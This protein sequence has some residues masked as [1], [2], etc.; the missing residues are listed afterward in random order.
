MKLFVT[1]GKGFVGQR[2]SE[3][4]G[5]HAAGFELVSPGADFDVTQAGAVSAALEEAAPDAVLHLA[6]RSHA[7]DAWADPLRSI[8][9]N[10]GGTAVLCRALAEQQFAGP[11][12][13]VS[14]S[15]VY[16][17]VGPEALPISEE[18]RPAPSNPYAA[19][20]SAA[21][22][23]ALQWW[24][25]HGLR[26]IVARPFP[27][28][29]PGQPARFVL[30][31]FARQVIQAKH[32]KISEVVAGDL[33]LIRDFSWVDDVVAAYLALLASGE[34]GQI[35]NVCSGCEQ[36]LR[37][38]LKRMMAL[39]DVDLPIRINPTRLRVGDQRRVVGSTAKLAACCPQQVPHP[40]SDAH[41]SAILRY[42]EGIE[43]PPPVP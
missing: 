21:E 2:V 38:L 40:L 3:R 24:R 12:L 37:S 16:G 13:I 32:G 19:S 15:D 41:L 23:V 39:A 43:A 9:V 8:V 31:S 26:V 22:E 42:W 6:A 34:P 7:P 25:S 10:V 35:Y 18:R 1:G 17:P 30:P 4:I 5:I 14:S 27:H 29:G 20:K 28:T 11:V 33:T 36:D